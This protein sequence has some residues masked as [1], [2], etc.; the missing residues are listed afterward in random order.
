MEILFVLAVSLHAQQTADIGQAQDLFA[1]HRP[2]NR[3][4][5]R[6]AH[7]VRRDPKSCPE[8]HAV[9]CSTQSSRIRRIADLILILPD[10]QP[11]R[12]VRMIPVSL[13]VPF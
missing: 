7:S 5:A 4:D 2:E 1:D 12:R 10:Q 9:I 6:E 3:C 11:A 8:R 13:I